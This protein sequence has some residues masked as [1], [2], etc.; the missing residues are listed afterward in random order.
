MRLHDYDTS[1]RFQA[2]VKSSERLTADESDEVREVVL[3]VDNFPFEVGQLIGVLVPG[4]HALGHEQHFRLYTIANAP[5]DENRVE[6]CVKRCSYIDDYS[7]EKYPG[8]SSNYLCDL[9]PGEQV[10][11]TGPYG[12][13]F[14]VPEDKTSDLIMIGL[15][16]GIAPFRA[17]VNHIYKTVGGWKGNVRLYHGARSGL[18]TLYMN[19]KRDDFTQYYDEETFSAFKAL[20]PRPHW[21]D[22]VAFH[23]TLKEH[24]EE[25]WSMISH[26]NT[27]VYVVGLDVVHKALDDIFSGMAGSKTQWERRKA[28]LVA[29]GRWVELVY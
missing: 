17:F 13:P 25:I 28:E 12:M 18:E 15:G 22:E 1:K 27:H 8:I 3:E 4:P 20:S 19:D 21:H 26:P 24:E 16:T 10:T 6:I 11:I 7:G 9:K 14:S 2:V 29:G 5:G 23:Q